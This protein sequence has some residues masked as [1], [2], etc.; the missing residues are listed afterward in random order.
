LKLD[1]AVLVDV[2]EVKCAE[3]NQRPLKRAFVVQVGRNVIVPR[4]RPINGR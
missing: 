2:D 3:A 4:R 1:A